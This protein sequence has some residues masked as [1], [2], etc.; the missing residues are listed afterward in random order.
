MDTKQLFVLSTTKTPGDL[1]NQK[2]CYC[3]GKSV[4]GWLGLTGLT[5]TVSAV[6]RCSAGEFFEELER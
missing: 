4:K 6:S 2:L 3:I 1:C 5:V